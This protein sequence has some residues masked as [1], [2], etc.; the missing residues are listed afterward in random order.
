MARA[1]QHDLCNGKITP[2]CKRKHA[3]RGM[4][5]LC[6]MKFRRKNN[7]YKKKEV[8]KRVT[9]KQILSHCHNAPCKEGQPHNAGKL[10][11]KQCKQPC[12]WRTTEVD[13][14]ASLSPKT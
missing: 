10:Y 11:C 4:C 1:R 14:I 6:Y 3:A 13:I 12:F 8:A 7:I 2:G 9:T 5:Q